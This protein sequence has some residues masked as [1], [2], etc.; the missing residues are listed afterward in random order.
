MS[1]EQVG[2]WQRAVRR[3]VGNACMHATATASGAAHGTQRGGSAGCH[4]AAGEVRDHEL[5]ELLLLEDEV[6]CSRIKRVSAPDMGGQL[7]LWG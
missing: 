5:L 6:A 3:V 2:L 4:I 7:N 1:G